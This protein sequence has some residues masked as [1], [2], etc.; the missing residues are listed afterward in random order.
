MSGA[1]SGV[2]SIGLRTKTA[3]AIAIAITGAL[4]RPK[5]IKRAEFVLAG[6]DEPALFQPYHEGLELPW[7]QAQDAAEASAAVLEK[8]AARALKDFVKTLGVEA[9]T[10]PRIGIV[11]APERDLARMGGRHIQAH[12]AEGVLF[13]RIWQGAAK[14]NDFS[15]QAFSDRGFATLFASQAGVPTAQIEACL[16]AIAATLG[17]PWRADEKAA[18]MAAWLALRQRGAAMLR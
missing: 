2:V 3:R 9:A 4:D 18:A 12:A 7:D 15:C 14:A 10:A 11:G 5:G 16:A 13:R 8:R 1:K 6:P 17:R